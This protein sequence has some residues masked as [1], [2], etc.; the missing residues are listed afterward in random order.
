MAWGREDDAAAAVDRLLDAAGAAFEEVGVAGAGMDDVARLAGCSRG[1]VYRY[2]PT[3]EALRTAFVEREARR[4]AR[5]VSA[6]VARWDDPAVALVEGITF[7]VAEVRSRPTL[8]AWFRPEAVGV[9]AAV[10]GGSDVIYAI[11]AA[12]VDRLLDAAA[13]PAG[14]V[15]LRP[16]LPRDGAV[17]WIVRV[18]LSLLSVDGPTARTPKEEARY[19]R[20]FLVP[21]LFVA[22]PG[23][24]GRVR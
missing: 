12:F 18:I 21:A 9:T 22:E 6:H 23:R 13:G 14:S 7:A 3:K 20:Q 4:L 5:E 15:P 11:T 24:A 17:E 8:A 19:L 16:G 10:A 1:T 2:F